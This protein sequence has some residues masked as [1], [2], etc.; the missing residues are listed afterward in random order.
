PLRGPATPRETVA[1]AANAVLQKEELTMPVDNPESKPVNRAWV[2]VL[3][4]WF[5][6][7][8]VIL[9]SALAA[10]WPPPG[11]PANVAAPT[12]TPTPTGGGRPGEAGRP[13]PGGRPGGPAPPNPRS[14]P[15]GGGQPGRCCRPG[16]G[17]E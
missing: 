6:L 8:S 17:A 7:V 3:S 1:R 10:F 5:V 16:C 14:R 2:A 9:I 13:G 12:A 15:G 4:A 11:A